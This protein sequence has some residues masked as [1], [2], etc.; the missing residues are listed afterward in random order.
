[1]RDGVLQIPTSARLRLPLDVPWGLEVEGNLVLDK[2]ARFGGDVS[3]R[4]H[5]DAHRSLA[6]G[7]SLRVRGGLFAGGSLSVTGS[8]TARS[9]IVVLGSVRSGADIT[10]LGELRSDGSIEAAGSID[11]GKDIRAVHALRAGGRISAASVLSLDFDVKCAEL[12]TKTLPL[13]REFWAALPPLVKH[14]DAILDGKNCWD[15][16]RVLL[17]EEERTAFV[18]GSGLHWTLQRQ[19]SNFFGLTSTNAPEDK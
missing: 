8:M 1:M 19:L 14:R 13:G 15:E 16:L 17:A 10:T 9:G 3:T 7:G 18:S 6:V 4:G 12:V 5:V 2:Q 11:A